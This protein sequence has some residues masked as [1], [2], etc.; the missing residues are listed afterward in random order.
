[1]YRVHTVRSTEYTEYTEYR[2]QSTEYL[3]YR[4]HEVLLGIMT[5]PIALGAMTRKLVFSI[6]E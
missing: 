5:A 3:E 1:M 6:V 2:V 4:V